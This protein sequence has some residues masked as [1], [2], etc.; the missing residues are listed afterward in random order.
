MKPFL[1]PIV[2]SPSALTNRVLIRNSSYITNNSDYSINNNSS[3]T[4]ASAIRTKKPNFL[5]KIKTP[6]TSQILNAKF[7][8]FKRNNNLPM[9]P[10]VKTF[11]PYK[12]IFELLNRADDVLYNRMNNQVNGIGINRHQLRRV[13]IGT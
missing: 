11:K 8:F 5:P 6:K 9:S 7:D 10:S 13:A 2:H 4:N 12:E 3:T 1:K